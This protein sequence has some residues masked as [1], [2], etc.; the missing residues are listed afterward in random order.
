MIKDVVRRVFADAACR[1][2]RI[3]GHWYKSSDLIR[4]PWRPQ[5]LAGNGVRGNVVR[6]PGES[7]PPRRMAETAA[8]SARFAILG[9]KFLRSNNFPSSEKR[10]ARPVEGKLL[11]GRSFES[12]PGSFVR[13]P[14]GVQARSINSPEITEK[15]L[16][17]IYPPLRT[18]RKRRGRKL[19]ILN[20]SRFAALDAMS[21]IYNRRGDSQAGRR[22]FDPG[23]PLHCFNN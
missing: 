16:P 13:A 8:W 5:Q 22:R 18:H 11:I 1:F 23:L 4:S 19:L 14:V 20:G 21:F 9:E 15:N 3:V 10:K 17:S 2:E 6:A 7:S 12:R